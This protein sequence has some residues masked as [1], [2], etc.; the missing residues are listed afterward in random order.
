MRCETAQLALSEAMD[1]AASVPAA[2]EAHRSSCLVCTRFEEGALRIRELTRFEALTPPVPDIASAVMQRVREYEAD[3][4]L[5]WIPE[6]H[7]LRRRLLRQRFALAALVSGMII[8]L[9]LTSGGVIPVGTE[10]PAASAEEIPRELVR[11]AKELVGFR[12][13]FDITEVNWTKQVRRRSFVAR[14]AFGAPESF[15]VQ[16]KD[17]TRY[18][19]TRWPRNDLLLVTDGRTWQATGPD[20]CPSAA[21]PDCPRPGPVTRSIINRSTFDSRASM[22][23][24]VIVPMK[25]LAALDRVQVIGPD[26]VGG[27]EA[28]A[29]ELAYQ[30]GAPLLQYLRFL[31]SWRPFYPQDR[32]VLWLD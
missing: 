4:M 13:T 12:A 17:T 16:V 8:G 10:G 25:V 24:D 19:S 23:T 6:P 18:P 22:P 28:V 27:R 14:L 26:R 29:V 2:V 32:V 31:G 3:R 7:P 11:A 30:D 5:G 20:P 1:G 21:L 9:V 15:R